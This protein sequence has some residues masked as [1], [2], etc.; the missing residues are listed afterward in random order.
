MN[1]KQIDSLRKGESLINS[2]KARWMVYGPAVGVKTVRR[3]ADYSVNSSRCQNVICRRIW[4]RSDVGRSDGEEKQ[5]D[6]SSATHIKSLLLVIRRSRIPTRTQYTPCTL[7]SLLRL[8]L[9]PHD[10]QTGQ[11]FDL[12]RNPLCSMSSLV[13]VRSLM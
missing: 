3:D 5:Q 13:G 10:Q 4:R 6:V 12:F 7:A 9:G 2:T 1:G 11:L 8:R